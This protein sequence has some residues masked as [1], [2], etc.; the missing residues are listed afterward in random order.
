MRQKMQKCTICGA[1]VRLQALFCGHCG[2]R[3]NTA[4]LTQQPQATGTQPT[5]PDSLV[6]DSGKQ[7]TL[8][9]QA[10]RK[11]GKKFNLTPLVGLVP[12]AVVVA[13]Q[14]EKLIHHGSV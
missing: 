14:G 4:H 10:E 13:A 3:I 11:E 1:D 8:K 9:E 2:T 5:R 7:K 6:T 12:P